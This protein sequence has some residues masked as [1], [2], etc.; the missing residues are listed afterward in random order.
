MEKRRKRLKIGRGSFLEPELELGAGIVGEGAGKVIARE[1]S[2]A[3]LGWDGWMDGW[4][5]NLTQRLIRVP[6]M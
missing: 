6:K 1:G 3:G 2:M 4:I 5:K